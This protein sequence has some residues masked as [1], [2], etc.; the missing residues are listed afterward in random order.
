MLAGLKM[1]FLCQKLAEI[2]WSCTCR[3]WTAWQRRRTRGLSVWQ[4]VT[5]LFIAQGTIEGAPMLFLTMT[6]FW[7]M[8]RKSCLLMNCDHSAIASFVRPAMLATVRQAGQSGLPAELAAALQARRCADVPMQPDGWVTLPRPETNAT[9]V[10]D[11][12]GTL[13][14]PLSMSLHGMRSAGELHCSCEG[15]ANC[16]HSVFSPVHKASEVKIMSLH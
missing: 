1:H 16:M 10:H 9:R 15:S 13:E 4:P 5:Q 11:D 2:D 8:N 7:V 12:L 3:A 6:Y 14:Y